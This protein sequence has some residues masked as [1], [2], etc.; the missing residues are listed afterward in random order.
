MT[1]RKVTPKIRLRANERNVPEHVRDNA[2]DGVDLRTAFDNVVH[3]L[4]DVE[5]LA[6]AADDALEALP[7]AETTRQRR[8]VGRLYSLV[9]ATAATAKAALDQADETQARLNGG[10]NSTDA[11]EGRSS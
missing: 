5:A 4:R 10:V 8:A 7:F 11:D 1:K 9:T 6:V 2:D 3:D